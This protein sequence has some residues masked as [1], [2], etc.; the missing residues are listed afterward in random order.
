[1]ALRNRGAVCLTALY[2]ATDYS[3]TEESIFAI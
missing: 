2:A 3:T 1:M